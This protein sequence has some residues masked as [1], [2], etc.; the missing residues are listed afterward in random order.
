MNLANRLLEIAQELVADTPDFFRVKGPGA[1]DRATNAFMDSLR[2]L[3]SQEFGSDYA[4]QVTCG[5]NGFRVDYYF[6]S[7]ATI[8]EAAL[9]LPK[10]KTE[11]ERDVLK[12]IMAKE[13]GHDVARLV[14]ISKP[15]ARKKCSKPGRLAIID[16]LLRNHGIATEV[17]ELEERD[18]GK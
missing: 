12:A 7:D 10:P 17:H 1:G 9:G 15:G 14:F 2:D 4:E 13:A 8:V 6:P 3:A 5:D 11:F 18:A 16:W